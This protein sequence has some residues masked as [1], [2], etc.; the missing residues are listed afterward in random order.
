L[1]AYYA[2]QDCRTLRYK[3]VPWIYHRLPAQDDL[4][5]LFRTGAALTRRDL[6]CAID[7]AGGTARSDRRRRALKKAQEA[8]VELELGFDHLSAFWEVLE[9]N[10]ATRHDAKPVHT[11]GEMLLLR[12]RFPDQIQLL[13]ARQ[14]G[15]VVAGVLLFDNERVSHAQYIASSDAGRAA[16]ALDAVFDA[17]IARAAQVGRRYFDFGVSTEENGHFLNQGLYTFKSGFGGAGVAHD[18]YEIVLQ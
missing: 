15:N 12:D 1:C 5:G 6:S 18:F 11:R 3:A 7:L 10:L 9:Q 8:G 17:A 13:A 16:S 2:E 14:G 4:Y